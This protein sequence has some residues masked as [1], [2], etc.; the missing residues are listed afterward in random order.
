MSKKGKW[1]TDSYEGELHNVLFVSRNKDNVDVENFKERR[2]AFVSTRTPE[3]L[4]ADFDFFKNQGQPGETSRF[5]YSVNAR[6]EKK[7]S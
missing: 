4:K 3:Q 1:D 5:Y 2:K 6:D 7:S